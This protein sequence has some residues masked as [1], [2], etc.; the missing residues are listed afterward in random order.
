[1]YVTG[2][3]DELMVDDSVKETVPPFEVVSVVYETTAPDGVVEVETYSE[4][5]AVP[6]WLVG[7][8]T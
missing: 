2:L 1:M 4:Y 5:E 7:T 8:V 6:P 3:P